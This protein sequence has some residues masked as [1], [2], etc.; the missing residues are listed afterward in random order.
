MF[1]WFLFE[2][3]LIFLSDGFPEELDESYHPEY[4]PE[5]D[6]KQYFLRVYIWAAHSENVQFSVLSASK[7]GNGQVLWRKKLYL[8][9]III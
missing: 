9:T 3:F 7:Y 1:K 2:Y 4:K 6:K 5:T 8:I